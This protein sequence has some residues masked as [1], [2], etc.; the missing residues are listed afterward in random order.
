MKKQLMTG[1]LAL[2]M[3]M[4]TT[5]MAMADNTIPAATMTPAE[6]VSA[7]TITTNVGANDAMIKDLKD[8]NDVKPYTAEQYEADLADTKAELARQVAA[9]TFTQAEADEILA[10]MSEILQGLKDGA[11]QMY[12]IEMTDDQG[13][14][15]TVMMSTL[16]D[17]QGDAAAMIAPATEVGMSTKTDS[18]DVIALDMD[19]LKPYTAELFEAE[20]AD[21]KAEL[22]E[23]V[24]AGEITQ[25]EADGILKERAQILQDIKDGNVQMYYA[26]LLD[27]NGKPTGE[28]TTVTMMSAILAGE[29]DQLNSA[30]EG[31]GAVAYSIISAEKAINAVPMAKLVNASK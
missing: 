5:S 7:V 31:Q 20:T 30:Q 25:A 1:A 2:T 22:T 26:E 10:D 13:K 21:L 18:V 16:I 9:S 11:I 8:L 17:A 27:E 29:E 12:S 19:A 28:I 15:M 23:Q 3:M 14:A 6:K 24:A 4:G